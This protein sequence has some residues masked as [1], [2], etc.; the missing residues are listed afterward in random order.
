[1]AQLLLAGS[2][3][4]SSSGSSSSSGGGAELRFFERPGSPAAGSAVQQLLAPLLLQHGARLRHLA[5]QPGGPSALALSKQATWSRRAEACD[6][7]V[8]VAAGSGGGVGRGWAETHGVAPELVYALLLSQRAPAL[9]LLQGGAGGGGL[10]A[11]LAGWR[12]LVGQGY[13]GGGV[14]GG[15][16]G[17]GGGGDWCYGEVSSSGC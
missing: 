9:V 13:L 1:V 17:S 4:G 15:S 12:A 10:A 8:V 11:W 16:G 3:D 5:D 6:L 7:A 14:C 2:G